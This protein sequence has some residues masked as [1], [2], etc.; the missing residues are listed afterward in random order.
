MLRRTA[1]GDVTLWVLGNVGFKDADIGR[2]RQEFVPIANVEVKLLVPEGRRVKSV[3]LVRSG[4]SAPFQVVG[5]YA[6]TV[7]PTLHIAEVVHMTLD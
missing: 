3:D 4:Q 2:M 7:I 5:K 1:K 6:V